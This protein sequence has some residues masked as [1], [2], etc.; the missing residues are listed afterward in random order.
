MDTANPAASSS[1]ETIFDPEESRAKDLASNAEDSERSRAPLFA[2]VLVL[3]TINFFHECPAKGGKTASLPPGEPL[4]KGAP[5]ISLL[6]V[7]GGQPPRRYRD[8]FPS[9]TRGAKFRRA[10]NEVEVSNFCF[11]LTSNE[12]GDRWERSSR[13]LGWGEIRRECPEA[14]QPGAAECGGGSRGGRI[15][16]RPKQSRLGPVGR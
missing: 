8:P 11:L 14:G 3:M 10:A 5:P 16:W 2:D 15:S 7:K 9:A 6:A 12:I 13:V 1:G 4:S